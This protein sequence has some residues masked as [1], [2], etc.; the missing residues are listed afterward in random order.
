MRKSKLLRFICLFLVSVFTLSQLSLPAGAWLQVT[1]V[2]I[3]QQAVSDFTTSYA[4]SSKYYNAPVDLKY[5]C[6]A[7]NIVGT[8]LFDY[9]QSWAY[10]SAGDQIANGGFSAD[11]PNVYV[12]VRHFYDPLALSGKNELTD[13][14]TAFGLAYTPIPATEWAL[15]N[16]ENPYSLHSAMLYYKKSMEIPSDAQVAALPAIGNF[17]DFAGTPTTLEEMRDMYL[18]KAMRGLGEVMHLVGDMTQPAHVRNDSHPKW[19][20][21]E[22]AVTQAVAAAGVGGARLD[23]VNLGSAANSVYDIMVALSTFT[24]SHFYSADTITDIAS[25]LSPKNGEKPYASPN[26]SQFTTQK[27][28]G[29][30]TYYAAFN[31]TKIPMLSMAPGIFYGTNYWITPDIAVQQSKVLLPLAV[32]ANVQVMN[33]FFPTLVMDQ[34]VQEV[35]CDPDMLAEAKEQ[36]A[37]ELKQYEA[38]IKLVH[39]VSKD[40]LWIGEGLEIRYSGPGQL[41]LKHNNREK[42][43]SD[44]EFKNG[45][46]VSYQDPETGEQTEGNPIFYLPAGSEKAI[47]L[48]GPV[49]DYTVEYGDAVYVTVDAGARTIIST[50]YVFEQE[51]PE[52]TLTASNDDILPG[53]KV[54]FTAE[55]K[56]PPERYKLE[57]SF[58]DEDAEAGELPVTNKKTTMTHVYEKGGDFTVTVRLIDTKRSIVRCSDSVDIS[59]ELGEMEGSWNITLKVEKESKI[60]RQFIIGI[61]KAL[62]RYIASPISESLGGGP[63]DESSAESFTMVGTEIYYDLELAESADNPGEFS[64]ALT[65][66]GS[67]TDYIS[68]PENYISLRM[69]IENGFVTFFAQGYDDYGNYI[70]VP[71]LTGGTMSGPSYIEGQYD[72][73]GSISGVW[74]ASKN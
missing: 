53:E 30:D 55:I 62:I 24:N 74:T 29:Y 1:H 44:V 59:S 2:E 48:T 32:A 57:W 63:I 67:N 45:V 8:G 73:G 13:Q 9:E 23:S 18:G 43:L 52:I 39:Q 28:D 7:P 25:G 46:L 26:F 17:R 60:F 51:E 35:A 14:E 47:S 68:G 71:F 15:W 22:Q 5:F 66:V 58:G 65:Y 34:Q 11:E 19:E 20:V 12:S 16:E 38:A 33:L 37:E 72:F 27:L 10:L 50:P 61:M 40:T 21:T 56:N 31:G 41:W 49:I 69:V 70:D 6:E 54:S 4:K 64:G 3:N 36:G 42:L